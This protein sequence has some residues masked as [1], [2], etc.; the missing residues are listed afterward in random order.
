VTA[1]VKIGLA[2]DPIKK[3]VLTQAIKDLSAIS[4]ALSDQEMMDKLFGEAFTDSQITERLFE[5]KMKVDSLHTELNRCINGDADQVNMLRSSK[6]VKVYIPPEQRKKTNEDIKEQ[7]EVI[8][9]KGLKKW[10]E[11]ND[12]TLKPQTPRSIDAMDKSEQ[13]PSVK[14]IVDDSRPGI[15]KDLSLNKSEHMGDKPDYS[16]EN[17]IQDQSRALKKN[18]ASI[19]APKSYP[20]PPSEQASR[21]EITKPDKAAEK[22]FAV[23]IGNSSSKSSPQINISQKQ[24]LTSQQHPPTSN[25]PNNQVHLNKNAKDLSIQKPFQIKTDEFDVERVQQP[26]ED[27]VSRNNVQRFTLGNVNENPLLQPQHNFAGIP[28]QT[29]PA[30]AQVSKELL[31]NLIQDRENLVAL[32]TQTKSEIQAMRV[33]NANKNSAATSNFDPNAQLPLTKV[34]VYENDLKLLDQL[35]EEKK[36]RMETLRSTLRDR[37]LQKQAALKNLEDMKSNVIK[38]KSGNAELIAQLDQRKSD[39]ISGVIII[40]NQLQQTVSSPDDFRLLRYLKDSNIRKGDSAARVTYATGELKL[41]TEILPRGLL[42]SEDDEEI[43]RVKYLILKKKGIAF[44]DA[45][46][47]VALKVV[48]KANHQV[49]FVMRLINK[50]GTTQQYEMKLQ[51]ERNNF[52]W[53]ISRKQ[54]TIEPYEFSDFEF[55]LVDPPLKELPSIQIKQHSLNKPNPDMAIAVLTLPITINW[56]YPL[57]K[58]T[59]TQFDH[60]WLRSPGHYIQ[61][62][63]RELDSVIATSEVDILGLMENLSPCKPEQDLFHHPSDATLTVNLASRPPKAQSLM[64]GIHLPCG[65]AG[66]KVV[67]SSNNYIYLEMLCDLRDEVLASAILANILFGLSRFVVR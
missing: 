23:D 65:L 63:L 62:E 41:S 30:Q 26:Y 46:M 11:M 29:P 48:Q 21:K 45:A 14:G 59:Q 36:R 64:A 18:S 31:Y 5:E 35:T 1:N 9:S 19:S 37:L 34:H 12:P 22:N 33:A 44:E 2:Y 27:K 15:L 66:F 4:S 8:R 50:T 3:D 57:V 39:L 52:Y 40:N 7:I 53:S 49:E 25:S 56:H 13:R 17:A 60:L 43:M 58:L 10:Q 24:T 28:P 32:V 55:S 38:L 6:G 20:P 67:I 51:N 54:C 47:K 16:A 42:S 61:T